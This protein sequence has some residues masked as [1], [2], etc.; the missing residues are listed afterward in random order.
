[1]IDAPEGAL[2]SVESTADSPLRNVPIEQVRRGRYQPRIHFD[3]ESLNEL[4]DS[5]RTQG[6]LQPVGVRPA[7][8]GF[9]LVAGERVPWSLKAVV[10][11]AVGVGAAGLTGPAGARLRAVLHR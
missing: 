8:A 7:G 6:V 9:E 5:I 11:L 10:G 1:L 2:E 4:A 3:P